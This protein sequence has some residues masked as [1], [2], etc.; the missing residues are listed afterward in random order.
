[1]VTRDQ[2]KAGTRGPP[3]LLI[4][5]LA[6]PVH[7]SEEG[8]VSRFRHGAAAE[9]K[10][11]KSLKGPYVPAFYGGCPSHEVRFEHVRPGSRWPQ[12]SF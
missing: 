1:M 8:D 7:S 5:P 11:L 10:W 12:A 3:A 4:G 9:E 6:A 2:T